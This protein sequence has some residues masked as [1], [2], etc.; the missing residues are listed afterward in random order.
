MSPKTKKL[1]EEFACAAN[2]STAG[3]PAD[4]ERFSDFVISAFQRGEHSISQDEFLE[5]VGRTKSEETIQE[6]KK[7]LA[8]KLFMF[9]KYEDGIRLLQ[10]F[11]EK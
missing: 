11:Q 3:N 6:K 7:A 5:M 9:N 1:L 10:N 2:W 8:S 4:M